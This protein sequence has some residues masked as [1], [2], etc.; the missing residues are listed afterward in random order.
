MKN[1]I[2]LLSAIHVFN[3]AV[4]I[5]VDNPYKTQYGNAAPAQTDSKSDSFAP[6]SRLVFPKYEPSFTGNG[7]DNSTAFKSITTTGDVFNC[8][9]VYLDINRVRINLGSSASKNILVY[10]IITC[11]TIACERYRHDNNTCKQH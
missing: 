4:G 10:R 9:I 3:L 7:T 1:Y 11:L 6:E 8:G 5:P 2:L